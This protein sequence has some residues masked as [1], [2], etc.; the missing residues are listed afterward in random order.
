MNMT[1]EKQ[2]GIVVINLE[3]DVMGGPEASKL[4]EEINRLLDEGNLKAVVNLSQVKRMNSSGLGILI[5]ALTTF[6]QN[7][8]SLKLASPSSLVQNLMNITKLTEIFESYDTVEA[9]LDSF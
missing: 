7:G 9:A 5:N 4:N 8:G 1:Q 3:G 6:K 2:Q